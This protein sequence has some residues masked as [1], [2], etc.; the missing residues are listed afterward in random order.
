MSF[1]NTK[2]GYSINWQPFKCN[3]Y[4]KQIEGGR[5]VANRATLLCIMCFLLP[6][7]GMKFLNVK[8]NI[9]FFSEYYQKRS[10]V[11]SNYRRTVALL[12]I[13]AY[14]LWETESLPS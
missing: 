13:R 8:S 12:G 1:C 4:R 2:F 9:R 14:F 7:V 11:F 10:V 3:Y 5:D 6:K